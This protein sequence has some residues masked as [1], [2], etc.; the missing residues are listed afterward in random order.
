MPKIVNSLTAD[1]GLNNILVY[2]FVVTRSSLH[3]FF[4]PRSSF[5]CYV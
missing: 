4:I 1:T 2:R 3:C 5:T